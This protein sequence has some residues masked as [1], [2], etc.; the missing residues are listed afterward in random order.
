MCS[1]CELRGIFDKGC[2]VVEEEEGGRRVD[3]RFRD[4]VVVCAH[5]GDAV[6][7]ASREV[8]GD[9]SPEFAGQH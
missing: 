9:F 3:E 5:E 8:V 1:V 7:G 6:D 2:K 4:E